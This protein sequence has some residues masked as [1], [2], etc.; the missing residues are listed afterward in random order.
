MGRKWALLSTHGMV[1]SQIKLHGAPTIRQLAD[2]LDLTERRVAQVIKELS[3]AGILEIARH[4]RRNVYTISCDSYRSNLPFD[5]MAVSAL[6][7]ALESSTETLPSV[8]GASGK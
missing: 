4:G 7:G 8:P 1:L 3:E 2:D 6:L 5:M